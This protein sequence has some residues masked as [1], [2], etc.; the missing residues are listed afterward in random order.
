MTCKDHPT[1]IKAKIAKK[2][3]DINLDNQLEPY[4][5]ITCGALLLSYP[6]S[7]RDNPEFAEIL[8]KGVKEWKDNL[9]RR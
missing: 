8:Q 1:L 2:N 3:K 4:C 7:L 9:P 5:C 6:I